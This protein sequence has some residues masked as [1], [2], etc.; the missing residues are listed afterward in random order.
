MTWHYQTKTKDQLFTLNNHKVPTSKN[1]EAQWEIHLALDHSLVSSLTTR[2]RLQAVLPPLQANKEHYSQ[3]LK[4]I[5]SFQRMQLSL[6]LLNST[7][8]NY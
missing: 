4:L 5:Y 1:R 3:T 8:V 6:M 7:L 2:I